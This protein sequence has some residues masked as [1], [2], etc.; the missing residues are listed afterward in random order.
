MSGTTKSDEFGPR[1][2]A[3]L[4]QSDP[5]LRATELAE[6]S[7]VAG[8]E[9][10]PAIEA[11]LESS[12]PEERLAAIIAAERTRHFSMEERILRELASRDAR[13]A[14]AAAHAVSMLGDLRTQAMLLAMLGAC[15]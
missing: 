2:E 14:G 10:W 5:L 12:H 13:I 9:L 15:R 11:L 3:M 8:S 4:R 7:L 1:I 6:L